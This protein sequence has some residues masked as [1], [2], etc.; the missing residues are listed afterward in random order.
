[1]ARQRSHRVPRRRRPNPQWTDGRF[2]GSALGDGN[3]LTRRPI[4]C[5]WPLQ[6]VSDGC[7]NGPV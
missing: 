3:Q 1:H 6:G 4:T 5:T 2:M 7:F